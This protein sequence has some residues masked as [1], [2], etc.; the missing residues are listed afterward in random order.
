MAFYKL[1]GITNFA[2]SAVYGTG[3]RPGVYARVSRYLDWIAGKMNGST[4]Q[5]ITAEPTS[6]FSA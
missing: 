2:S 6:V 5:D 4:T 1:L 3:D